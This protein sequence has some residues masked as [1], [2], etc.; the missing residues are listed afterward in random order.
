MLTLDE[1]ELIAARAAHRF[2]QI[3]ELIVRHFLSDTTLKR[4]GVVEWWSGEWFGETAW[5]QDGRWERGRPAPAHF[6][7]RRRLSSGLAEGPMLA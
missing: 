1:R 5:E 4:G 3:A 6:V 7:G 2:N